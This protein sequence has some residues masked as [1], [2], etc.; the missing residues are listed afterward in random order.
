MIRTVFCGLLAIFFL[1][2]GIAHFTQT[3]AFVAIVPPAL[4]FKLLI[5]QITGAVE[6]IFAIGLLVP[7]WR[8][9]SGWVLAVYC[10]VVLPANIYMAITGM[11]LGTIA[12]TMQA[13]WGRVALQVPLIALILWASGAAWSK[14][15]TADEL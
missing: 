14:T 10:V 12:T 8:R 11:P 9:V 4:P 13:L 15:D 5:V 2:A 6:L 1:L 3:A 7:K